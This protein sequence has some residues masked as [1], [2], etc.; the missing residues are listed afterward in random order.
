MPLKRSAALLLSAPLVAAAAW[1]GLFYVSDPVA[2]SSAAATAPSA[3]RHEAQIADAARRQPSVIN[4]TLLD[5]RLQRLMAEPAMVGMAVGVVENGEI[6]FLKGYG[7]TTAGGAEP[8]S[9]DT[10]FRW[11][12][13][14]KGVAGDMVALLS[15]QGKLGLYEPINRYSSTLR[16]PGGMEGQATV[17]DV[18]SHQLGLFAHAQD[19]K[20]E[21]GM[22]P[23]YLRGSLAT[24][25]SICGA[26][27]CHA[28]QNV[29]FDAAS[30]VVERVTGVPYS[31]AVRQQLFLPL[32]MTTA[33]MDRA[34]L[35]A[36]PSWARGHIGGKNPRPEPEITESYYRVPAAGGVNG[37]IKDLAL[38]MRAQMGLRPGVLPPEVLAAVQTPRANTPGENGR[39][40][41]FRERTANAAYGLGWRIFDYAGHK[42]V[43]HRGGVRGYRSLIMFDP[44]RKSGVVALWNSSTGQPTGLEYELMDQ[45]YRLPFEDWLQLDD[46]GA[47]PVQADGPELSE[48]GT[49]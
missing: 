22:D 38:W 32:G 18:L 10:V 16:L 46:P 21:D 30:E 31:Q 4:Y 6:R 33:S 9:P 26:G 43:A 37:T 2:G 42:V 35:M 27:Q 14:S 44:A 23:Q 13:L 40:R 49:R 15:H 25:N 1:A 41:K 3:E 47:E 19:A 17:A 34:S 48:G 5:Q 28:Y 12:S 45:V 36:A 20:L 7:V 24:L 11:A 39:R 29:A 8:V